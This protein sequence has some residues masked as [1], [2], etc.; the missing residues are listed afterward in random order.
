MRKIF[1]SNGDLTNHMKK[2][3]KIFI[4]LMA[5]GVWSM[6]AQEYQ[7]SLQRKFADGLDTHEEMVK[8]RAAAILMSLKH[9]SESE[10]VDNRFLVAAQGITMQSAQY[11]FTLKQ[12]KPTHTGEKPYICEFEDCGRAFSRNDRLNIHKRTHTGEKPYSCTW[13]DCGKSFTRNDH[14]SAHKRSHTGEKPYIC[15]FEDC[16]RAFSE[17]SNLKVHKRSHTGEKHYRCEFKGCDRAFSRNDYLTIH[18][19]THTGEKP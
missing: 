19:L 18:M 6:E 11:Q 14:L 12:H 8:E 13:Q 2:I 16:G 17:K 4:V 9:N 1:R 7:Q 5:A 3:L 15:E 10:L